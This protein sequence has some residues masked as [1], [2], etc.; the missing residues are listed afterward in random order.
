MVLNDLWGEWSSRQAGGP[1]GGPFSVSRVRPSG[2]PQKLVGWY[3]YGKPSNGDLFGLRNLRWHPSVVNLLLKMVPPTRLKSLKYAPKR[4]KTIPK[5]LWTLSTGLNPPSMTNDVLMERFGPRETQHRA[6]HRPFR[7][8][9]SRFAHLKPYFVIMFAKTVIWPYLGLRGSNLSS[10]GTFPRYKPPLLV[11][12][13]PQNG[14]NAPLD[15]SFG[16]RLSIWPHC[17]RPN[18]GRTMGHFRPF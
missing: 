6:Y 4:P 13:F 7:T 2:Q 3:F 8:V 18:M 12:S 5:P 1:I 9:F 16:S 17:G 11:V 10:E 14:P 15:P